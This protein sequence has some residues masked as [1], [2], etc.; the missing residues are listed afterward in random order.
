MH[1]REG[2]R[3]DILGSVVGMFRYAHHQRKKWYRFDGKWFYHSLVIAAWCVSMSVRLGGVRSI[4]LHSSRSVGPVI[5]GKP[6]ILYAHYALTI[7]NGR[8]SWWYVVCVS[9]S[10]NVARGVVQSVKHLKVYCGVVLGRKDHG[11]F[12]GGTM[13]TPTSLITMISRI[14]EICWGDPIPSWLGG[15][16]CQCCNS[17]Q[18]NLLGRR[19]YHDPCRCYFNLWGV[20]CPGNDVFQS[21]G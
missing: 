5:S 13:G 6:R 10:L 8:A 3:T 19:G 16:Y 4:L 15:C 9:V 12:M 14:C 1:N 17:C 20:D 2:R 7:A 21:S 18:R 11:F